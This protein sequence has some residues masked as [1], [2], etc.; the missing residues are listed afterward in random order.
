MLGCHHY[1]AQGFQP[2]FEGLLVES[3]DLPS[4]PT[5]LTD[6]RNYELPIAQRRALSE[7]IAAGNTH[8]RPFVDGV[9]F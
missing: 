3:A 4:P 1:D 8:A 9:W 2:I 6:L 7:W 5:A